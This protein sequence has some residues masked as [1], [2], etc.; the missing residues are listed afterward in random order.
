MKDKGYDWKEDP[1]FI[2]LLKE[3]TKT[4]RTPRMYFETQYEFVIRRQNGQTEIKR[5]VPA[6]CV[7]VVDRMLHDDPDVKTYF[8]RVYFEDRHGH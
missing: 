8:L 7:P 4:P 3:P 2:P 5:F 6:W 1:F